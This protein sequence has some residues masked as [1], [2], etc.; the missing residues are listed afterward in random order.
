MSA[1]IPSQ[2]AL[3]KLADATVGTATNNID[4]KTPF[5]ARLQL[6]HG[7]SKVR[8]DWNKDQGPKPDEGCFWVG[9]PGGAFMGLQFIAVP[10]AWRDH[11]LQTKG[12]TVML[13]SYNAP[14]LGQLPKTPDEDVFVAIKT[15]AANKKNQVDKTLQ[16]RVGKDVLLWIPAQKQA[17]PRWPGIT[18][19]GKFAIY[20]L[21]G[22]AVPE[23]DNF[24]ANF[25]RLVTVKSHE[26]NGKSFS[27][28]VPE[29]TMHGD[30]SIDP[31]MLP[32]MAAAQDELTKFANPIAK[33]EA[34]PKP[35]AEG[36]DGRA[37]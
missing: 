36:V 27:W 4:A 10:L 1:V 32:D 8:V 22:T 29:V 2:S 3:A 18:S 31:T 19:G 21:A 13:E 28:F 20:Y 34:M 16:N 37:R 11:A 30:G 17:D 6:L 26:V 25:G 5:T 14:G 15:A 7:P 35:A 33:G 23:A 9:P 24:R 12:E